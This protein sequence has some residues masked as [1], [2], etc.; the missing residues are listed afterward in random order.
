MLW[1]MMTMMLML[2][3]ILVM[4]LMMMLLMLLMMSCWA[5]PHSP[6]PPAALTARAPG[7]SPPPDRGRGGGWPGLSRLSCCW[8][9]G[10]ARRWPPAPACSP[11][12]SSPGGGGRLSP[13]SCPVWRSHSPRALQVERYQ[14]QLVAGRQYRWETRRDQQGVSWLPPAGRQQGDTTGWDQFS[15]SSESS[16]SVSVVSHQLT[17][18]QRISHKSEYSSERSLMWRESYPTETLLVF[19]WLWICLEDPSSIVTGGEEGEEGGGG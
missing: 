4:N 8:S 13:S 10:G 3:M 5:V 16:G 15:W 1:L 18:Q 19:S 17:F 2:L 6:A 11:P 12:G 9:A 7:Q 14:H